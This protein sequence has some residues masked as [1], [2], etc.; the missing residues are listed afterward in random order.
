MALRASLAGQ[1]GGDVAEVVTRARTLIRWPDLPRLWHGG[2]Q[3]QTVAAAV[4]ALSPWL[5][6]QILRRR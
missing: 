2:A 5:Y 3:R 1:G 6:A 4:L